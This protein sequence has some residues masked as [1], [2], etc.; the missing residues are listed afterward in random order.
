MSDIEYEPFDHSGAIPDYE[1]YDDDIPTPER[2]EMGVTSSLMVSNDEENS[3]C[4][5]ASEAEDDPVTDIQVV[6]QECTVP[7]FSRGFLDLRKGDTP[8]DFY[9]L[10]IDDQ[11]LSMITTETNRYAGQNIIFGIANKTLFKVS[12]LYYWQDINDQEVLTFLAYLI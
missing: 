3:S 8:Y 7:G 10:F 5:E 2:S 4:H 11:I 6:W 1:S 12:Q 9:R